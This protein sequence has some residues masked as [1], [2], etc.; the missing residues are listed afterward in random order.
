MT[1]RISSRAFQLLFFGLAAFAP[2]GT[3]AQCPDG[4]PPPGSAARRSTVARAV[5]LPDARA[6]RF[7]LVPFRNVTRAAD[8]DWLVTGIPLMLGEALGQFRDLTVVPEE[9]FTAARRR[10]GFADASALDATQLRRLADETDGWTVVTG[11][12][13]KSG[14]GTRI[15]AQATDVVTSK[16]LARTTTDIT[17]DADVRGATDRVAVKLLEAVG[18]PAAQID[19]R[20]LT[21]SSVDAYRAYVRGIEFIQ[22]SRYRR[23]TEAFTEAVKLDSTFALAWAKLALSSFVG[24]VDFGSN[25]SAITYRAIEQAA[26]AASRLPNRQVQVIRSLQALFR[27]QIGRSRGIVD[28]IAQVDPDDLDAKEIAAFAEMMDP[29][30][31]SSSATPRRRGSMNHAMA[32]ARDLLERDPGR[33]HVYTVFAYGYGVGAGMWGGGFFGYKREMGSLVGLMTAQTDVFFR[34]VLRDTLVLLTWAEYGRLPEQDR[35]DSRR[36]SAD[37]ANAWVERW[38]AAGPADAEAHMFASRIAELRGELPRALRELDVADSLG[39]ETRLESVRGRRVSLLVQAHDYARASAIADSLMIGGTLA[40]RPINQVIDPSR[41][42]G[43]A[44]YLLARRWSSAQALAEAITP[45]LGSSPC[46]HYENEL[47]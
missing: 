46:G 28:S 36:R 33:R 18:V 10:L 47:S 3:F 22:Q 6:R 23:A 14:A 24:S 31:D 20:A 45:V 44:A 42:Y 9:R 11:N 40:R 43:L 25:P 8:Q 34:P 15:S 16:V 17:G 5:P 4:T 37:L 1:R 2:A 12:I 21:T 30:M 38:V 19:V 29:I 32:V 39:V 13:V 7:L 35:Q 41:R 26:R 27:G